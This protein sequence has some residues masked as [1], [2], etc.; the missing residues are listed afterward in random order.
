[1]RQ[2]YLRLLL[3][4]LLLA[5]ILAGCAPATTG[6]GTTPTATEDV[7]ATADE[8]GKQTEAPMA[9]PSPSAIPDGYP[10]TEPAGPDFAFIIGDV[11]LTL[12]ENNLTDKLTV[13]PQP[14]S[15]VQQILGSEADTFSGSVIRTIEYD[16]FTMRL[17]APK[18]APDNFWL[19]QMTATGNSAKTSRGIAVGDTLEALL[20]QYPEAAA[21][22]WNST[23]YRYQPS[24]V[25]SL[26]EIMFTVIDGKLT[27]ITMTFNLP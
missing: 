26:D 13:M 22:E 8:T 2:I 1:M 27:M 3:P 21:L 18:D 6:D 4:A 10:D 20:D 7:A 17:M 19:L 14:V 11:T 9:T 16:G 12:R 15:D 24:A 23:I 25:D 5:L